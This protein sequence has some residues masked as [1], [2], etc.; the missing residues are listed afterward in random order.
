M[1]VEGKQLKTRKTESMMSPV[2]LFKHEVIRTKKRTA[3]LLSIVYSDSYGWECAY[4]IFDKKH[5]LDWWGDEPYD[6]YD[7]V[8]YG[9]KADA[10]WEWNT[11]AQH[12]DNFQDAETKLRNAVYKL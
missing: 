4:S 3:V 7:I 6:Y 12:C 8:D 2:Q 10:F 9:E 5:F 1:K 11:V